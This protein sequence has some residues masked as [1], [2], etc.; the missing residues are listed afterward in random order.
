MA[1][2]DESSRDGSVENAEDS[3]DGARDGSDTTGDGD[4]ND[5]TDGTD[6][7][8]VTSVGTDADGTL[9]LAA[10]DLRVSYGKVAALRGI[11]LRV[12]AGEIVSMIGPNGAGKST[13]AN[14]ASGF[15]DYEGSVRHWGA[16]VSGRDPGALV[17]DGLVHCTE[18]RDP[19]DYL[20]VEDNLTLGAYRRGTDADERLESVYEL[21]LALA[22]RTDQ[23]ART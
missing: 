3:G 16:E 11:D 15:L 1:V 7:G 9:M 14:T 18:K 10:S 21:F 19:F 5:G 22:E 6:T 4:A 13:L 17:G 12:D 20:S 8:G 2:D 23:H